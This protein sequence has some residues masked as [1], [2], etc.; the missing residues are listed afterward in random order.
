MDGGLNSGATGHKELGTEEKIVGQCARQKQEDQEVTV[1]MRPPSRASKD[2]NT[3]F[4]TTGLLWDPAPPPL[5]NT[6]GI[7]ERMFPTCR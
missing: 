4:E 1:T 5:G 2:R 3:L 6:G 7:K